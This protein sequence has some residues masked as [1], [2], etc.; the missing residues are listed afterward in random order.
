MSNNLIVV[1]VDGSDAARTAFS[2]VV[3]ATDALTA[4]AFAN[5]PQGD[6]DYLLAGVATAS[7]LMTPFWGAPPNG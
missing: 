4:R 3:V 5:D 7:A 2:A 1:G 6:E